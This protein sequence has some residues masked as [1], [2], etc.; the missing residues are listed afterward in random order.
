MLF[1]KYEIQLETFGMK[2]SVTFGFLLRILEIVCYILLFRVL[3]KH[4]DEMERNNVISSDLNK[5]R[6]RINLLSI[7]VQIAGFVAEN[8]YIVIII[9]WRLVRKTAPESD[10]NRELFGIFLI[11]QFAFVST[12]PIFA[13]T[14]LRT[15]LFS[16]FER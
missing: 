9:L 7:Y 12:I 2:F 16:L 1:N 10:Q 3:S 11:F 14:E 8:I 6:R 5:A 4:N 13:S 15:K